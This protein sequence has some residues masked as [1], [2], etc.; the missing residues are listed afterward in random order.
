MPQVAIFPVR[1]ARPSLAGSGTTIPPISWP[2]IAIS[3]VC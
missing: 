2:L 3:P 1:E